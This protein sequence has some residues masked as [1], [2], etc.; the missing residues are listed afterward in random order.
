LKDDSEG[1]VDP[2]TTSSQEYQEDESESASSQRHEGNSLDSTANLSVFAETGSANASSF[3]DRSLPHNSFL[4]AN[5]KLPGS[6]TGSGSQISALRERKSENDGLVTDLSNRE[7]LILR[8][9][10]LKMKKRPP[11]AVGE[12]C[13][14]LYSLLLR[15]HLIH[16]SNIIL[17]NFLPDK[18]HYITSKPF[19]F[20]M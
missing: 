2:L 15:N 16:I 18:A 8:K 17:S 7:R 10:A 14:L 4:N 6:S 13:Y 12:F 19:G 9:Q 11:F 3:H 5:R 1:E 20:H